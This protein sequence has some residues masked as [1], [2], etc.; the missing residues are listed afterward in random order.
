MMWLILALLYAIY[1]IYRIEKASKRKQKFLLSRI[2]ELEA[3][4]AAAKEAWLEMQ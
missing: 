1:S 4:L 3:E 2:A